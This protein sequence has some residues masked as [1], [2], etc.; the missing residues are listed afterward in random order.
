M[1]VSLTGNKFRLDLADFSGGLNDYASNSSIYTR[2]NQAT[3]ISNMVFSTF[4]PIATRNGYTIL[5]SQIQNNGIYGLQEYIQYEGTHHLLVVCNGSLYRETGGNGVFTQVG[6]GITVDANISMVNVEGDVY[7]VDGTAA[8]KKYDSAT[9]SATAQFPALPVSYL[10]STHSPPR[11]FAL[12]GST[13]IGRYYWCEAGAYGT[14]PAANTED[15][16]NSD[17]IMGGGVLFGRPVIFGR[18][19]IFMIVGTDPATWELRRVNSSVGLASKHPQA[20]AYVNGELWFPSRDGIYALGGNS[21]DSGSNYSFD[22]IGVT[23]VSK[24]IQGTWDT[25]NQDAIHVACASV[26]NNKYKLCVP[27][28][29]SVTNNYTLYCDANIGDKTSHPWSIF[30]YGFRTICKYQ[31]SNTPFMYGGTNL[32]GK[33]MKLDTGTNDNGVAIS[34]SYK[35]KYFDCGI[36]EYNKRFEDLFIW[37]AASGDW[38]ITL[39]YEIDFQSDSGGNSTTNLSLSTGLAGWGTMVWGVDSW[40]AGIDL[41]K[42]KRCFNTGD[43]GFTPFAGQELKTRGG[44]IRFTVSGNTLDQYMSLERLIVSGDITDKFSS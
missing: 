4:G 44:H 3:A 37:T 7:L 28:S 9:L 38:N 40:R 6:T 25:I 31:P 43:Y 22:N 14:W 42:Q 26:I 5:G 34:C 24:D 13:A 27:V 1:P 35:T 10:I 30:D 33:V 36:A 19:S 23:K 41:K 21:A 16:P 17:E 18:D 20:I 32:D 39:G 29:P 15:L 2:E 8:L 12:R 11:I